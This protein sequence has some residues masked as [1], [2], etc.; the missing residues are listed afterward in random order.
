MSKEEILIP[1]I[2]SSYDFANNDFVPI[3]NAYQAM[4]IHAEKV[5]VAFAEWKDGEGINLK[6][7][8]WYVGASSIRY[9]N[10]SD[11]YQYFINNVYKP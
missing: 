10:V 1:L 11:L 6:N 9:K 2:A 4:D 7:G 3:D 8:Y 5:A